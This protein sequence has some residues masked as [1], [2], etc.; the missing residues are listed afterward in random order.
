MHQIVLDTETTGLSPDA[1]HRIIEIAAV[2]LI[3]R[4]I[5]KHYHCY[6]NPEREV[7]PEAFQ[8]HG[9]SNEFLKDKP[10][11]QDIVQDFLTFIGKAELIIHNAAFDLGFLNN[12]L[13]LLK[14]PLRIDENRSI[15][16]TLE[17]AQTKHPG[18]RNNLNALCKRYKITEVS[19]RKLH[20]ALLDAELLAAV[21][22]AMTG[23]QASLFEDY[24]EENHQSLMQQKS[25]KVK[26]S[27]HSPVIE[28][29]REEKKAHEDYI[30]FL[31]KKS[32]T[33]LW[34]ES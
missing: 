11:F 1:G 17:L 3:D 31:V 10:L 30:A 4:K 20:G 14:Y 29:T 32:G 13:N 34:V 8:V 16:D 15:I 12:E 24:Q 9:L 21:Y 19:K 27:S 23:G 26:L 6:L 22:L 2:E 18:L 7:D 5:N 25:Q 33:N 28:P